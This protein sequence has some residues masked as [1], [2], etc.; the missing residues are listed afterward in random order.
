MLN[1]QA[2]YPFSE[3]FICAVI[4]VSRV[5][6]SMSVLFR[7]RR[8]PP[9]GRS[10]VEHPPTHI[11]TFWKLANYGLNIGVLNIR[12]ILLFDF[13]VNWLASGKF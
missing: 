7:N 9:P 4:L 13:Y 6:V 2:C 12:D 1:K 5:L 11:H 3:Y 10:G 8:L